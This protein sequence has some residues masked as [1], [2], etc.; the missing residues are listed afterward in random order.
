MISLSEKAGWQAP[1]DS[2]PQNDW[3]VVIIGG[4]PAGAIAAIHLSQK[5]HRVLLLDKQKFPREKI[6]GDGLIADSLKCIDNAQ[7]GDEVR[8]RGHL[9]NIATFF[10]PSR[11][12]INVPGTYLILKR[13]ILDSI[14][15]KQ[16]VDCGTFFAHAEVKRISLQANHSISFT[17]QGDDRIFRASSAI[18]ATGANVGLLK[19]MGWMINPKPNAVAMRCYVQS[20]MDLNRIVISYDKIIGP[21]YAWIFPVGNNEYNVGCGV[22]LRSSFMNHINLKK[23]FQTFIKEFPLARKLLDSGKMAT[24]LKAAPLR[25]NFEGVEQFSDGSI[26]AVGEAIGTTYPYTGEG[27]GKAMETGQL[28]ADLLHAALNAGDFKKLR[29]YPKRITEELEPRYKGYRAAEKWLAR[30]WL[31]D[32]ILGRVKKSKHSLKSFAGIF[33]ETTDPR[34]IFSLKGI[35]KSYWK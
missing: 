8:K 26:I 25:C 4:G 20:S 29:E 14:L 16:A 2:I 9:L 32:F 7:L 6:C 3:D 1:R 27:I 24:P 30:P 31:S 18:V 33:S 35:I 23:T 11:L 15:A 28:G 5:N 21:G 17:I 34:E 12:E 13:Y 19:K 22:S 10:S